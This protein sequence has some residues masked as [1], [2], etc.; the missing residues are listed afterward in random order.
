MGL[1]GGPQRIDGGTVLELL[2]K[3]SERQETSWTSAR[4]LA[5]ISSVGSEVKYKF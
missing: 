1:D 5:E 3:Y 2:D 4:N